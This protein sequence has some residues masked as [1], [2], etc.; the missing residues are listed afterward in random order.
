MSASLCAFLVLVG[1]ADAAKYVGKTSQGRFA[2]VATRADGQV[3]RF[4][5]SYSAPCE[6]GR[7]H[8]FP[9]IFRFEPPFKTATV[10]DVADTVTVRTGLKGGGRVRQTATVT[11]HRVVDASGVETWSGTFKTRAVLRRG[12]KRFDVC[13]LERVTWSAS[14]V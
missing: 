7:D 5:I 13:A 8:R 9:N 2:S 4:R 12:G 11:A 6:A 1:T 14:P 3:T 10:D